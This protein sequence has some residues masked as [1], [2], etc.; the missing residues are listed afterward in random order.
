MSTTSGTVRFEIDSFTGMHWLAVVLAA[1]TGAVHLYLFA[2]QGWIPFLLAGL[3]FFGAIGLILTLPAYRPWLYLTG[4]PYTLAQMVGWY[5]VEQP[6]GLGDVSGL[7]AF[8][9]LVQ[10]LLI[11]LLVLLYRSR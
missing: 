5:V 9:K 1:V 2:T 11:V 6:A 10:I 8:D 7:A 3:G 4:I